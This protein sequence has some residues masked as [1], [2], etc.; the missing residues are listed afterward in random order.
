M[1][2]RFVRKGGSSHCYG[3][4]VQNWTKTHRE[5]SPWDPTFA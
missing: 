2:S 4:S 5:M 3:A 1:L